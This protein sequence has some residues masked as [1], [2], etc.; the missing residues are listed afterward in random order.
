[1]KEDGLYLIS[2]FILS[3]DPDAEFHFVNNND[4]RWLGRTFIKNVDDNN[5]FTGTGVVSALFKRNDVFHIG[6]YQGSFHVHQN[7]TRDRSH[8]AEHFHPMSEFS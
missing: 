4:P 6:I 8:H 5:W 2:C 7:L 1:M 3:Y